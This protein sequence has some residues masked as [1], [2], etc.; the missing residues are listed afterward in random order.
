MN[1]EDQ[2]GFARLAVETLERLD[3]PY[4]VTGSVASFLYGEPRATNDLDIVI[5]PTKESLQALVEALEPHA[6]V[7]PEAAFD[8]FRRHQMFN[9][10]S[11]E[12]AEKVDFIFLKDRPYNR[13]AFDRRLRKRFK[14]LEFIT[15]TAEDSVLSKLLW[16]RKSGSEQQLR[17]V[18]GV[19]RNNSASTDWEYMSHWAAELGVESLLEQL[20]K[21]IES[22][23]ARD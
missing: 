14:T 23:L 10:V 7:S 6:Y 15:S 21:E 13:M 11:F 5:A 3:I 16:A 4:M 2:E 19:L 17:D 1:L 9:A 22:D 12:T 18:Y 8:A 20:R